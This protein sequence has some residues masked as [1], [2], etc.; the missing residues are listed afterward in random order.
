MAWRR[1]AEEG[2]A[3]WAHCVGLPREIWLND[4]GTDVMMRPCDAIHKLEGDVLAEGTD[5]TLSQANEAL[6]AVSSG[7]L[8]LRLAVTWAAPARSL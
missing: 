4:E 5:M 7:L 2:A 1:G 8:Y 6:P 3:G